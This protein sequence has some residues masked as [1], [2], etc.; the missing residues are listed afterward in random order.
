[1][2]RWGEKHCKAILS[3]KRIFEYYG[4][5]NFSSLH[6][7]LCKIVLEHIVSNLFFFFHQKK[8]SS[9]QISKVRVRNRREGGKLRTTVHVLAAV[10]GL[11]S[12][13]NLEPWGC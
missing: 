2:F 7:L 9:N 5:N 1:M 11:F 13:G 4:A 12:G 10:M 3:D 8:L 6:K